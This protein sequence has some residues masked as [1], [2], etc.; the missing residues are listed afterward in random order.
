MTAYTSHLSIS[1]FLHVDIS[2]NHRVAEVIRD[3]RRLP[4][5]TPLLKQGLLEQVA[6]G[7]VF[8][9]SPRTETPQSLWATCGT[10][11][12]FFF[13]FQPSPFVHLDSPPLHQG[14]FVCILYLCAVVSPWHG[15][16][17]G[18]IRNWYFR[19]ICKASA[20]KKAGNKLLDIL[21]P[22]LSAKSFEKCTDS[23]LSCCSG[24]I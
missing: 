12:F 21:L 20:I 22:P 23:S 13:L 9:V 7:H 5:L 17:L 15:C 1:S 11:H 10:V 24:L 19:R 2:Q 16:N 3:F 6:Q 18:W 14:L 4:G 8:W